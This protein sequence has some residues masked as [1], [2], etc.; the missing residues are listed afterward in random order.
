MNLG[1]THITC[2]IYL[3][4]FRVAKMLAGPT[5][6]LSRLTPTILFR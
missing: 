4:T 6:G 5:Y 2:I 1:P 3:Y